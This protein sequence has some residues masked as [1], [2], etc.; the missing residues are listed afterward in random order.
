M[1]K[2]QPMISMLHLLYDPCFFL[3]FNLGETYLFPL[4]EAIV[5]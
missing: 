1:N 3:V 4:F 2:D 5:S